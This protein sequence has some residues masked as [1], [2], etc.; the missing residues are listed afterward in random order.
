VSL[1]EYRASR[2]LSAADPPFY[3]LI[4]AAM[5]RADGQNE[6]KLRAM[7]PEVWEELD[8]RY[9]APAGLLPGEQDYR[10][11]ATVT[12]SSPDEP[13]VPG[14]GPESPGP[15]PARTDTGGLPNG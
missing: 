5:R 3:A 12:A 10:R 2:D 1:F 8:A 14:R 13:A 15:G 6:A 11:V 7:W 9:N 4:M